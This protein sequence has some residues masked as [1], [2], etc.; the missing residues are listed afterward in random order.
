[1]FHF[2]HI[3]YLSTVTHVFFHPEIIKKTTSVLLETWCNSNQLL[4]SWNWT[5]SKSMCVIQ[6]T[7][8]S[9]KRRRVKIGQKGVLG[10][11][12]VHYHIPWGQKFPQYGIFPARVLVN[13]KIVSKIYY[14]IIFLI[15]LLL[16]WWHLWGYF[17]K[18]NIE[19]KWKSSLNFISET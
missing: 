19:E 12:M 17:L 16:C 11:S 1:M 10:Y 9:W 6:R 7:W 3:Y 13:K 8:G 15:G 14:Q 2:T 18:K 4:V 5:E